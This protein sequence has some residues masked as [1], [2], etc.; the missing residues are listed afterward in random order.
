MCGFQLE[1]L[2]FL[3]KRTLHRTKMSYLQRHMGSFTVLIFQTLHRSHR[4]IRHE[5]SGSRQSLLI[6][7]RQRH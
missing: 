7:H 2:T 3:S 5:V 6:K 1:R 4:D